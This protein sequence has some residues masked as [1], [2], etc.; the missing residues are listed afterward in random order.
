MGC[1]AS[2]MNKHFGSLL[3]LCICGLPACWNAEE[4][5]AVATLKPTKDPIQEEI[6]AFRLKMRAL[7][8]NRRF[9]ELEPV[10]AEIRRTNPPFVNGAWNIAQFYE[11]LAVPRE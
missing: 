10:A 11:S 9:A 1:P 3:L 5:A 2:L 7:Y 4:K 8:N 6:Y